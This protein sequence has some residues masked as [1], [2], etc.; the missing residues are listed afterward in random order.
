MDTAGSVFVPELERFSRE[1]VVQYFSPLA[2]R[3]ELGKYLPRQALILSR[4]PPGA[5]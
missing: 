1:C 5:F 3:V 4:L 2:G